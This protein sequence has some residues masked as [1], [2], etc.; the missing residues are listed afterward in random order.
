[1]SVFHTSNP[2]KILV[3]A[4]GISNEREVSLSSGKS[5]AD[6]LITAGH[7]V[8]TADISPDNL[9]ALDKNDYDIV[10]P[11]LHGVFGEDGQLQKILEEKKIPFVGS[12]SK[13]S[14]LAMDKWASKLLFEQNGISV[15]KGK[16]L[17]ADDYSQLP[18]AETAE[19]LISEMGLPI[20]L[21][22]VSDGSSV[23]VYKVND[24]SELTSI[25]ET[26]F[27]RFGDCLAEKFNSGNEYTVGIVCDQVLPIIQILPAVDFYDYEAKYQRDDTR[28]EYD[29]DLSEDAK[30]AMCSSALRA[31]QLLGCKDLTRI[32]F[33]MESGSEPELMEVNTLPGFTDHS[34]VPKAAQKIGISMPELCDKIVQN[35]A[36]RPII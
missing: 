20:V 6:A 5:V 35:A 27:D 14:S 36:G 9:T 21:K 1:M 32:D 11:V 16:L 12:G 23:G 33:M 34:L 18:F 2:L 19:K 13:A 10:F 30:N 29:V 24:I 4:G 26:Y 22:P 31:Y 17:P 28:Y 8:I 25:L 7:T 15:T 3:L